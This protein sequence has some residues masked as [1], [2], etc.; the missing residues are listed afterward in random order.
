MI[1]LR[2]YQNESIDAMSKGFALHQRQILCLPTGAGKTV[3]FS[4]IVRRATQ[5]NTQCLILTDRIELFTQTFKALSSRVNSIQVLSANTRIQDFN[6]HAIVTVA[7]VETIK[8]RFLFGYNP[9]LIIIDEAHKGNFNRVIETYENAKVIGATATPMGKHIPEFYHNIVNLI[10]IP[11]L[12]SQGYLAP[13]RAF[14]MQDDFSDLKVLRNEYTEASQFGHFNKRKLYAGVVDEWAK[15]CN[16]KKTIVFNCNIEHSQQM[17]SE[18]NARG[19]ESFSITSKTPDAERKEIL[20][21]F[22]A[23]TFPVLNNCG[24]LT[25]GYDEPS[26]E[27]VVLNRKTMSLPL[28]LQMCGRGSR[29][30]KNK[31]YFTV[32][33]FGMN[34]SEHGLWEDPREWSLSKR[35]KGESIKA[36][37]TKTCPKCD[38][39]LP[40]P[41]M[42]CK[43]CGFVYPVKESEPEEGVMV[44][45]KS[46]VSEAIQGKSVGGLSVAELFELQKSKR[47]K[48]TFVWRIVRS[49]GEGAVREFAKLAGYRSGWVSRQMETISDNTVT[50][51][52]LR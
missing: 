18:F 47:Y 17:T 27:C 39:M 5:K 41:I 35:K 7:M 25:T 45:V 12:I 28:Y 49:K 42:T 36:G 10:D 52:I 37:P 43:F 2:P 26:I 8:R 44:E 48:S 24:I 22:S 34:H 3:V 1:E 13:C 38:A 32:L 11:E 30:Y 14:Q 23:G 19:I 20:R 46:K 6:P 50:N 40:A 21:Q 9:K 33:D 15:R 31:P 29:I 4:E 51:F 16:G